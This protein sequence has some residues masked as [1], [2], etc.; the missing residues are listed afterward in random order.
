MFFHGPTRVLVVL[1]LLHLP[2]LYIG[3]RLFVA[4]PARAR[5]PLA[6]TL[7]A[8]Q[9]PW[10]LFLAGWM[11]TPPLLQAL[12]TPYR[13]ASALWVAG[14]L[15]A[16]LTLAAIR[17]FKAVRGRT[18][19]GSS[20]VEPGRRK[21]LELLTTGAKFAPWIV[22]GYGIRT[23]Y[24]NHRVTRTEIAIP[25]LPHAFDGF[26][27]V[28]LTD[29][30]VSDDMPPELIERFAELATA[31]D[32][33]V[34][35]LTGDYLAFDQ[36]GLEEC[37]K[38]LASIQTRSGLYGCLGNHE[39]H[40]EASDRITRE[41]ER[42][43]VDVLRDEARNFDLSPGGERLRFV[44]VDYQRS[45]ER[46]L[47][48]V[49]ELLSGAVPNILL[50]HNPNVFPHAAELGFDLTLSGHTHGGQVRIEILEKAISPSQFISPYVQ[51]LYR[52]GGSNLYVSQGV[53]TSGLPVRIGSPPEITLLTLRRAPTERG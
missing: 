13:A 8:L 10:T 28:Q 37:V 5:W 15:A 44:G 38:A 48:G 24:V 20:P 43:G 4:V 27:I 7:V 39:I 34:G 31:L 14:A 17:S 3:W 41:F 25:N 47:R 1:L 49:Q 50:S 2:Q 33:D 35:M 23:A 16:A 42:R 32:A 12:G 29:I 45:R 22:V 30:H 18:I 46:P 6:M 36:R 21:V 53:G 11:S 26:R 40:T 52:R 19:S 9:L 51:G